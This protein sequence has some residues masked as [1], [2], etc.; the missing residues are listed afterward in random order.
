MAGPD[1]IAWTKSLSVQSGKFNLPSSTIPSL[2]LLTFSK[3]YRDLSSFPLQL[4]MIKHLH[5]PAAPPRELASTT[6]N[7]HKLHSL[8]DPNLS[9]TLRIQQAVC[10]LLPLSI[11]SEYAWQESAAQHA[12]PITMTCGR[13][14]Q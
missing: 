8:V 4:C 10:L 11:T 1:S 3:F 9:D 14:K 7:A 2:T 12:L 13:H 5:P 6:S